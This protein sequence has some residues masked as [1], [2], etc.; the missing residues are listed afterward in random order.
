[1][2]RLVP[3]PAPSPTASV[4]GTR[5]T[6]SG[7]ATDAGPQPRYAWGTTFLGSL[8]AF[9]RKEV[10]GVTP[11]GLRIN[12]HVT[13]GTFVGAGF[14]AIVLPGAADWMR[15]RRDGIAIVNVQA[16]F[17]TKDGARVFGSY[18]GIFD[19]GSDGYT[20]ALRDDWADAAARGR[21]PHVC[22]RRPAGSSGSTAPSAW[23]WAG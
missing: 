7:A 5:A 3:E 10:V 14:D 6:R 19:L 21:D 18:G 22:D 9:L 11:D 2:L 12:W 23:A 8:T 4:P 20:R 17:E 16:C 13:Q 15:I 1:M